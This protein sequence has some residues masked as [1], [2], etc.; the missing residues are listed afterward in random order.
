MVNRPKQIGTAA[1]TA[2]LRVALPYFPDAERRVLHGN[3]D[4]GDI[5][6]NRHWVVEVKG[7]KQTVQVGDKKLAGWVDELYTEIGHAGAQHGFLVLQ[8][9]G[10]GA[11]NAHRW[12]AYIALG[13]LVILTSGR[14]LPP[15]I[16][17]TMV[18]LELGELLAVLAVAGETD[19]VPNATAA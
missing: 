4:Q 18:R 5:R 7:G 6:L 10:V 19:V 3:A 17:D 14:Q 1:E 9:A 8:R 15:E 16:Y 13:E 12:W 2:T 11:P